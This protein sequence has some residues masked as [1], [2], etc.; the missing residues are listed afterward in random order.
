MGEG[1]RDRQVGGGGVA[2]GRWAVG[3]AIYGWAAGFVAIDGAAFG[4]R[5]W[6]GAPPSR[7]RS[8]R[9]SSRIRDACAERDPRRAPH[10]SM[11]N[12]P[13]TPRRPRPRA[14]AVRF[15]GR[16]S[17]RQYR[18][19]CNMH[20]MARKRTC[21]KSE[22]SVRRERAA[23]SRPSPARGPLR[24]S[25]RTRFVAFRRESIPV[26]PGRS[27]PSGVRRGREPNLDSNMLQPYWVPFPRLTL[28]GDDDRIRG[29]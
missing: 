5:V 27:T 29:W 4:A 17:R 21:S 8:A 14:T 18:N 26:V 12:Q 1:G 22:T 9:R 24:N 7:R 15:S 16:T 13:H 23:R 10:R 11:T 20:I 2:V 3:G 25:A 19:A 6:K 28:A